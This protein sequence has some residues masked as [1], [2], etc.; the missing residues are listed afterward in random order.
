MTDDLS[1]PHYILILAM[2]IPLAWLPYGTDRHSAVIASL[3]Y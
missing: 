2:L 1:P 3:C